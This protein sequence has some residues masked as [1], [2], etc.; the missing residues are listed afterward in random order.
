MKWKTWA[1]GVALAALVV[2]SPEAMAG[3]GALS[4]GKI[5]L[6][7]TEEKGSGVPRVSARA[8]IDAPADKVWALLS[9]CRKT[10][11]LFDGI[12]NIKRHQ[13]TDT[14]SVC[15]STF[16]MPF[17]FS[18]L[19]SKM[20]YTRTTNGSVR[21]SSWRLSSGDFARSTGSWTV[22]P[23]EG[24]TTRTLVRYTAHAEPNIPVP[25]WMQESGLK[26][27]TMGAMRKLRKHVRR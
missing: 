13:H 16:S 4:K 23:Y 10:G 14:T 9:D 6:K 15:S 8:V 20:K 17:P 22:E 1:N 19:S 7:L 26:D 25:G 5:M 11:T 27:S 12:K 18:D 21:K 3:S 2:V 24:S